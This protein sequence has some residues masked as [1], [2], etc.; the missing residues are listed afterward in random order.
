MS[1]YRSA[2]FSWL[3]PISCCISYTN[4]CSILHSNN[5]VSKA[6]KKGNYMFTDPSALFKCKLFSNVTRL[7]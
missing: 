2:D 5:M 6:E 4:D 7:K 3:V 1:Y